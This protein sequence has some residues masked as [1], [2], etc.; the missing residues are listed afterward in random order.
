MEKSQEVP[1]V[2]ISPAA[3]E[4]FAVPY[5]RRLAQRFGGA[6]VHYCGRADFLTEAMCASCHTGG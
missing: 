4:E 5:T 6:W 3:I 1:T 2:L